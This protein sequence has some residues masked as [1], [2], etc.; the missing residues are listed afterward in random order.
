LGSFSKNVNSRF[1]AH[2]GTNSAAG[3]TFSNQA[4]GM[5][6]FYGNPLLIQTDH[7]LRTGLSADFA[8]LAIRLVDH[9]STLWGHSFPPYRK[10]E[11]NI[12]VQEWSS[13][14]NI[15]AILVTT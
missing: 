12:K 6:A 8:A 9:N 2:D 11:E 15:I 4:G 10:L 5:I 14:L 13:Y 3:T 7:M 1:W